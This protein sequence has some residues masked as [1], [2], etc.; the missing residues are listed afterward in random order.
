MIPRLATGL[1]SFH[2]TVRVIPE[3]FTAT[4]SPSASGATQ[5]VKEEDEEEEEE[6]EEMEEEEERKKRGLE[7]RQKM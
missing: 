2:E 5:Q 7:V 6:E 1:G 4:A 3:L